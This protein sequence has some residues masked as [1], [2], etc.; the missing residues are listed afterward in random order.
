MLHK[1]DKEHISLEVKLKMVA[2]EQIM[3]INYRFHK[4]K[5]LLKLKI[6]TFMFSLA[7]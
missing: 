4:I 1:K 2:E 7:D 3:I 6:F 5:C